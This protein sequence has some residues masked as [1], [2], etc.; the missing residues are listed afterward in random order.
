MN[1]KTIAVLMIAITLYSCGN[2]SD[3]KTAGD[4]KQLATAIKE[5]QPGGIATTEGGW[6]MKAKVGGK[7]W[8]ANS[9][10][11]PDA[12]GRI[13]G[14]NAGI[15]ISLPYDRREMLMGQKNTF[16]HNNAVDLFT[17]DDVGIWGVYAGEMEI[18]KVDG[19]WVEGKFYFTGTTSSDPTKK[20]EVTDGFFRISTV[21]K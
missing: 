11:P 8:S 3:S 20:M 14:D 2:S 18:T 5:M 12:A 4:A 6:T 9:L 13:I 17:P 7:E 16:S 15:T 10:M 1:K 19:E 21:K